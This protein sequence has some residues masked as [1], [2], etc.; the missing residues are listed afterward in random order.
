MSKS[1][2][3]L[4]I[5]VPCAT[6]FLSSTCIMVLELVAGRLIARHLGASLYTWTS[7]I[8]VVLTGITIGNYVGGRIADRFAARKALAVLFGISSAA[9]VVTVVLNN[10]VG[11]WTF[12]WRLWLPA[13]IFSHVCLVFLLPSTLLG[14]ISPVVAKMALDRGLPTGRTVGDIYACGAAGSIVGTFLAGF[15]LIAAFGTVAIIW[16][17]GAVLLLMAIIYGLRA[18]LVYAWAAIFVALMIMGMAPLGFTRVAGAA[19]ALRQPLPANVIYEDESQYCYIAVREL[20]ESP[21]KRQFLQDTWVQSEIDMNNVIDMQLPYMQIYAAL[22]EQLNKTRSKLAVLSIGG[23][24][25]I[26]PRYVENRWAGSR[27]DVVEI[28]PGVTEAAIS[29]FGLE[30]DSSINTFNMDARNYVDRLLEEKRNGKPL[31]QYDI[32][33][34]DAFSGFVVPYQLAT[35]EFNDKLSAILADGGVYLVNVVDVFESGRFLGAFVNTLRKTF[36]SVY[37]VSDQESRHAGNFI[38]AASRSG[39]DFSNLHTEQVLRDL[40]LWILSDAEIE[41]LRRK[42]REI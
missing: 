10:L 33:F 24:G 25:Y 22:A 19:L 15:Y 1:R 36:S 14:T 32:I 9:C 41:E 39:I 18:W 5:V 31:P 23:G 16:V 26:M 38:V 34:G 12:L 13:R 20:S 11:E 21:G 37:V 2:D 35:R 7:V 6:V 27:I 30:P 8:G 3:Y 40:D 4:S 28:D 42:S 29:A 17:V